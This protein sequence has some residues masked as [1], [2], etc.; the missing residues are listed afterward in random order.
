MITRRSHILLT[1]LLVAVPAIA[2][3][4]VGDI[5]YDPWNEF[6]TMAIAFETGVIAVETGVIAKTVNGHFD[7]AKKMAKWIEDIPKRYY[8]AAASWRGL[9]LDAAAPPASGTWATAANSGDPVEVG[10]A[11]RL[12][13]LPL[14][15]LSEVTQNLPLP[16][17]AHVA[18]QVASV[19]LQDGVGRAVLMTVGE[20]RAIGARNAN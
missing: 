1:G 20:I 3:M 9:V 19:A 5:V 10:K 11:W 13:T 6:Q 14:P 18:Q 17:V 7:H 2:F 12:N 4:G 8:A 16:H 15:T